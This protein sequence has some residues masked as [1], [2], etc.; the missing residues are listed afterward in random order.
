MNAPGTIP[1]YD[2]SNVDDRR[3]SGQRMA[4]G[5][6]MPMQQRLSGYKGGR[7]MRCRDYD[8]K[9]NPLCVFWCDVLTVI[10]IPI[11]QE[12]GYCLR[13]DQCPY[14]HGAD[15]IIM[16]STV[17]MGR[18]AYNAQGQVYQDGFRGLSQATNLYGN[19]M[20]NPSGILFLR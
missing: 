4:G 3:F 10:D 12:Q 5:M 1:T 15:R 17:A 8:G 19:S 2:G 11:I 20:Q 7:R 18:P 9:L 14:E 6:G 13:G 16:D